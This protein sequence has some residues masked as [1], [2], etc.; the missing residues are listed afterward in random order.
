[1]TS[2]FTRWNPRLTELIGRTWGH[3]IGKR[4]T[5]ITPSSFQVC[6]VTTTVFGAAPAKSAISKNNSTG[7]GHRSS[8][9]LITM[10]TRQDFRTCLKMSHEKHT[11]HAHRES[12]SD[13]TACSK[14]TDLM[15]FS[16]IKASKNLRR[17]HTLSKII[18][19][20]AE[21]QIS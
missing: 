2:N 9:Y 17:M 14:F 11:P 1:M 4:S 15:T 6:V 18:F 7:H 8:Q 19:T 10:Y 16:S 12:P 5:A 20:V 3:R 21:M 13:G